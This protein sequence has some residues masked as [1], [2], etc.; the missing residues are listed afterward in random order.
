MGD[1]SLLT[2]T[3]V[4]LNL[5]AAASDS[6][7]AAPAASGDAPSPGADDWVFVGG[8]DMEPQC[9]TQWCWAAVADAVTHCYNLKTDCTQQVIAEMK[10]GSGLDFNA[11][12]V[13]AIQTKDERLP[14]NEPAVLASVLH[15]VD[16]F[17]HEHL[18]PFQAPPPADVQKWIN[19]DATRPP[20]LVCVRIQWEDQSG[21]FVVIDGYKR[22]SDA[23][24]VWDPL[25]AQCREISAKTLTDSYEIG[26]SKG[27]SWTHTYYTRRGK[28]SCSAH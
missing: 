15:L 28:A 12:C 2:Q 3:R 24:R 27:G 20:C 5:V 23:L 14:I 21:H 13:A 17:G 6:V 7:L 10:L 11:P 1:L 25:G 19:G 16:C 9:H 4:Q 26:N 8:F 22:N 18:I